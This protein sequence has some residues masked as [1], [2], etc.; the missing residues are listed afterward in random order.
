MDVRLEHFLDTSGYRSAYCTA[1][2]RGTVTGHLS[3]TVCL[4]SVS[5]GTAR[6]DNPR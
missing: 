2:R 3:G 4:L 5:S 1:Y 6:L